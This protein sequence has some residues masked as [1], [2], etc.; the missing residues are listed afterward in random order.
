MSL[1]LSIQNWIE[2]IPGVIGFLREIIIKIMTTLHLPIEANFIVF[3][4]IAFF[5]AYTFLRQFITGTLWAKISTM[6]NLILLALVFYLTI[7]RA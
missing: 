3:F 1:L 5:L 7:T 2:K 4:V 6:L